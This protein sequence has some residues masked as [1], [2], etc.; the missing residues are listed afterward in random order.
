MFEAKQRTV[1]DIATMFATEDPAFN[2]FHAELF[3]CIPPEPQKFSEF[4]SALRIKRAAFPNSHPATAVLGNLASCVPLQSKQVMAVMDDGQLKILAQLSELKLPECNYFALISPVENIDGRTSYAMGIESINFIRSLIALAFGK[5][6]FYT[7]VADFDFN[8][9]GV[10]AMRGD[11]VRLPMH[12]DLFRI[13][14][15]ALMNEIAERLAVQ[16]ADYRKRLQRACNFFDSA[17]GQKD[18]AFRFSSYWIALEIIVGGKS[19]AIR[20]KLSVAYGQQNKSFANENLFFKEIE[21]IR[22]NLIHKGDFGLLT[23]YQERLMQLYFWDIVIHEIGLK[24]R[25]LALLFARSGLV[26]EE[27]NRVV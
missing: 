15:A 4:I 17:L 12:G 9:N 20:S 24:P 13:V 18:E 5:L 2:Y 26:A 10:L 22:N 16:Q 21:G 25:G 7:W 11:I 1:A 3:S 27:K 6:P 23:S 8:A 14:D 19:D